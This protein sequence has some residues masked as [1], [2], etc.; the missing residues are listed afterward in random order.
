MKKHNKVVVFVHGLGG[1]SG[2][3]GK[4]EQLIAEDP[5]LQWDVAHFEYPTPTW[6][7]R[8]LP[9]VQFKYQPIQIL[10]DGLRT[11]IDEQLQDYEEIALVGHSLGGLVVRKYLLS[12]VHAQRKLRVQKVILYAVPNDGSALAAI[13]RELS[14]GANG[15]VKQLCRNSDFLE[16]LRIDWARVDIDKEVDITV[17]VG[18]NDHI[19]SRASAEAN[20]RTRDS[21]PKYI[22]KAGHKDIVKPTSSE[23]LRFI[24]LR[25]ALK[26]KRS[27]VQ[28]RVNGSRLVREWG[29][30]R[31]STSLPFQ[32]DG[33]RD[34]YLN[35]LISHFGKPQSVIRVT[36]LSGLGKTR[37]VYEAAKK[38]DDESNPDIVY[39]D[40]ANDTAHLLEWIRTTIPLGRSGTL[41]V[42]NCSID[43][44]KQLQEEI[45]REDSNVCLITIDYNPDK[46]AG[47]PMIRVDRFADEFI[48]AMLAPIY[49]TKIDGYELKKIVKF[50]QGFPRLAVL[51]ADARL[52]D[53]GNLGN[54]D[55]DVIARKLLWGNE[56][57][58]QV[59]E[60]ILQ[61]CALFE[62][63][64]LDEDVSDQFQFIANI[65]GVTQEEFY[66]C[67]QRFVARGLIDRRGRF[68]QLVPKPLA[69]RLA[70]QWWRFTSRSR[71]LQLINELPVA[72]E[73]SFCTQISR[74]DFLPEVKTLTEEL[75][76]PQGPFGRAEV[77]LSRR[78][79]MLFRSLVEVNPTA[80]AS[81]LARILAPL[82]NDELRNI[83][84]ETRRNLV[85]G[86][87]KLSV[88][89]STFAA[90]AKCLLK[91]AT[92]ENESWSN[93]AT[94]IFCQLFRIYLSG[95]AAPPS[96]RFAFIR[97]SMESG[98]V[99]SAA[100]LARALQ[101][102]FELNSITRTV[103]AEYQ[104]SA[105]PIEEWKPELWQEVFD[106]LQS[107]GEILLSIFDNYGEL[108]P[109]IKAAV[110]SSIRTLISNGRIALVDLLITKITEKSGNF[111]PE[112]LESIKDSLAY[113]AAEFPDEG[114]ESLKRWHDLLSGTSG[115][116]E[117][118]IRILVLNPPYEHRE[119][120]N[121][122]LVDIA[123]QNAEALAMSLAQNSDEVLAS[124][125]TLLEPGEHRQTFGFGRALAKAIDRP[126]DLI[127]TV[128]NLVSNNLSL[129]PIFLLGLLSGE[130]E[131]SF[132]DWEGDLYV[133]E[134]SG[135]LDHIYP[136][137]V[138]TGQVTEHHLAHAV[139]LVNN[140]RLAL[141]SLRSFCYGRPLE[142]I[143]IAACIDFVSRVASINNEKSAA[144]VAL[145]ILFMYCYGDA[146][147]RISCLPAFR[148]IILSCELEESETFKDRH[149]WEK[150]CHWL[151]NEGDEEVAIQ[152]TR[153]IC[154][155]VE[156]TST[157]SSLLDE[158]RPVV[159]TAL[160]SHAHIVWPII[161]HSIDQAEG[162]G[163]L[164]FL[165]I[166]ESRRGLN[167]R[168]KGGLISAVPPDLLI[169][170]CHASPKFAPHFIA[171][172]LDV[173]VKEEQTVKF[174]DFAVRLLI[175]FEDDEYTVSSAI[176]ANMFSRGW[177]GSLVPLLEVD[178]D[179]ILPLTRHSNVKVSSWALN[180]VA[181]LEAEIAR[182]K[183]R[184]Q[185]NSLE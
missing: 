117:E 134:K 164:H 124:I 25:N 157:D 1:D 109:Q 13:S 86:L 120:D 92:A 118:R 64:G 168:G 158:L 68:A 175:D 53:D 63:F 93:N 34:G 80:T 55:D 17:V 96:E 138:R 155:A 75:C 44:H 85:W 30:Y 114:R 73:A 19:V 11:A 62:H 84:G 185:E 184:D 154:A 36:G 173:L 18:G 183:N 57:A 3:W 127:R 24:I 15:H 145:D 32:L 65:A 105:P 129:R 16:N 83:D 180:F 178:K 115:T 148:S 179:A 46:V 45:Q 170:W 107:A 122:D 102:S 23:D 171:R 167:G 108:R 98:D 29:K 39:Y 104:G 177:S 12:E 91:L 26:K 137:L 40:A 128:A 27:L 135:I 47:V 78:G 61:G 141:Q 87:E 69:V 77:I 144:W 72:M 156:S 38:V 111:W 28:G 150:A 51:L 94:G 7:I 116:L 89:R 152:I 50:A 140:G 176:E 163:S 41:I 106:Y 4:F 14:I 33:I 74:L 43:L 174:N 123:H 79:S 146:E 136:D 182:E 21:E 49:Q 126:S 101:S 59:S 35:A 97:D 10:A 147:K 90:A 22:L 113:D 82:S 9:F 58:S 159:R 112:A 165:W 161:Q 125:P 31:D 143:S 100:I 56:A 181:R 52:A 2:T 37:L 20:F 76:G 60:K 133:F 71:Q 70:A 149:E 172:S 5:D 6:G 48:E 99:D 160:V 139:D 169:N 81:L 151:L 132:S 142:E 166:F 95:T 119:T 162:I 130:Y 66:E 42:D 8:L 121:G 103:G 88:R 54:L 131:K 67:I 153:K 110:G